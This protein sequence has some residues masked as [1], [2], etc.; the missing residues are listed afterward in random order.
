MR[1]S[2]VVYIVEQFLFV[3]H[4]YGPILSNKIMCMPVS[5][6]VPENNYVY[7]L[8][9]AHIPYITYQR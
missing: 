4:A 1:C 3:I 8:L 5:V 2:V 6:I 9:A 7:P